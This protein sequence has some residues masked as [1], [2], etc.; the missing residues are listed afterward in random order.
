[1]RWERMG[2]SLR[3]ASFLLISA[4]SFEVVLAIP[5]T[6]KVLAEISIA[7][8]HP[9]LNVDHVCFHHQVSG[10]RSRIGQPD[11]MPAD[12]LGTHSCGSRSVENWSW[13]D[14]DWQ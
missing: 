5:L 14:D 7:P 1:M 6:F 3:K 2:V 10:I 12:G 4:N 8:S 13:S 9:L 11:S